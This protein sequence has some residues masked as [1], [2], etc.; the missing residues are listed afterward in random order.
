MSVMEKKQ[1]SRWD[2]PMV[3][4]CVCVTGKEHLNLNKAIREDP[5]VRVT[6]FF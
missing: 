3:C 4:V 1:G 5:A 2:V 6:I